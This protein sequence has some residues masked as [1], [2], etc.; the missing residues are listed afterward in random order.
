MYNNNLLNF[1]ES[2]TILNACTKKVSK[3]YWEQNFTECK[4]LLSAK[5]KQNIRVNLFV[6]AEFPYGSADEFPAD[7]KVNRV[8][9]LIAR[10]SRV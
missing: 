6:L 5:H 7:L 1:Q 9:I 3:F 8:P 10:I 2:M 4:I